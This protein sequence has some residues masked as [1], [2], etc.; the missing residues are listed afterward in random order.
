MATRH[1]QAAAPST[2]SSEGVTVIGPGIHINGRISGE[3]DLHI[4]GRVEGAISL[5]ETLFVA[6]DGTVVAEVQAR[7]VVVSGIIVGNVTAEDSVTLNPGA[8]L[9][10]DIAAPRLIIADGAA[11]SGNV[12]MGGEP[13][14]KRERP[15][16]AAAPPRPRAAAA[17]GPGARAA[18]PAGQPSQRPAAENRPRP[19]LPSSSG[20]EDEQTIVV[21]HA[22]L[23]PD[24][25]EGAAGVRAAS[26][27]GSM[28][29]N[30]KAPPRRVPKPGKR[31]VTKR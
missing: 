20:T 21:K 4:E 14:P 13:P 18:R 31:R 19:P 10:G 5:S 29:Q 2:E 24:G 15:R 26:R 17:T 23:R 22:A 7:D 25:D 1:A 6:G 9:V 8:K 11:F 30:S 12:S 27:T 16:T 28:T 3:E